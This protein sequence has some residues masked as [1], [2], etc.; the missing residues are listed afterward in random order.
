MI[1]SGYEL[2]RDV[3]LG[4]SLR[5]SG[6]ARVGV[7]NAGYDRVRDGVGIDRPYIGPDIARVGVANDDY[8]GRGQDNCS[9]ARD[10][11]SDSNRVLA[12]SLAEHG[13]IGQ[14][15]DTPEGTGENG[16]IGGGGMSLAI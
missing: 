4:R 9:Y 12:Y 14:P 8:G 10:L 1:W 16:G 6:I 3:G 15:Y 5:L 13:G 7:A 11:T 2:H